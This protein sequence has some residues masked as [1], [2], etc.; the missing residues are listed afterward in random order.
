MSE[1]P[2]QTG[3]LPDSDVRA[4]LRDRREGATST[5]GVLRRAGT[6]WCFSA[7]CPLRSYKMG[8][9]DLSVLCCAEICVKL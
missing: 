8:Y 5:L 3:V 9:K 1:N 4:R 7:N 6:V 2:T